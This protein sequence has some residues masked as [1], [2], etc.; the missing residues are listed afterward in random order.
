MCARVFGHRSRRRALVRRLSRSPNRLARS[1]PLHLSTSF[2]MFLLQLIFCLVLG[3]FVIPRTPFTYRVVD[4]V[5]RGAASA[6]AESIQRW[7]AALVDMEL[8]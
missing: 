3:V 5:R 7:R 6:L 1:P 8:L 4:V 2:H